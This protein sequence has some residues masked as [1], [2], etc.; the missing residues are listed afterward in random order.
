MEVS[1]SP[2][3]NALRDFIDYI[4]TKKYGRDWVTHLRL[5]PEKIAK[6]NATQREEFGAL[7]TTTLD[8]RLLYYSQFHE[9]ETIMYKHWEDGFHEA[10]PGGKRWLEVM[11][12]EINKLRNPTAHS[13]E[14]MEYQKHLVL[15]ITGEIRTRI[16]KFRGLKDDMDSYFPVIEHVA[17]SL[18]NKEANPA[19]GCGIEASEPVRVGDAV[20]IR[21]SSTDPLGQPMLYHIGRQR[22]LAPA[23][24]SHENFKT[25]TFEE[26]DIGKSCDIRIQI[27]TARGH[28][29]YGEIDDSVWLR[30]VV[31]PASMQP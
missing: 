3:E 5:A 7:T 27:K 30:Y 26:A 13:R 14:L 6:W 1:I 25:I 19:Y 8:G 28:H 9:L 11:L 4:L 2:L 20:E 21:V 24:W 17:D 15:G 18:G 22:S 10:F 31:L 12:G 16:M 29:A 23:T